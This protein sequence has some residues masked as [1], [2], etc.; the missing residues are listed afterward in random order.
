[1]FDYP[2]LKKGVMMYSE[3]K[4]SFL[5]INPYH[6]SPQKI[7]RL[8]NNESFILKMI[9]GN[10][11]IKEISRSLKFTVKDVLRTIN[12]FSSPEWNAI[13]LL[14][15]PLVRLKTKQIGGD[16]YRSIAKL[17]HC[18]FFIAKNFKEN[19]ETIKKYHRERISDAM[20]Q[21]NAVEVTVSHVYREPHVLLNRKNYGAAFADTLINNGALRNGINILEIGGGTGIFGR[22][23]LDEVKAAAPEIYKT[24]QY[25]F[26][27]LSPVLLK[28]QQ[29]ISRGH[30][31]ITRFIEGDIESYNFRNAKL[32]LII[33]NEMIADLNVVK[34]SKADFEDT[35]ALKGDRKRAADII[36]KY[37]ISISNAPKEF[38]FNLKA[39]EFLILIKKIL[40][41]GGKAY[42]VEYGSRF[43]YS[44]PKVLKGHVEYSIH[45]GHLKRVA[46]KLHMLPK[47]SCLTDF[48]GFD[49]NIKVVDKVSWSAINDYLLPF[50]KHKSLTRKVYTEEMIKEAIGSIFNRLS[51]VSFSCV[52]KGDTLLDPGKFLVLELKG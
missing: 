1:M 34:L 17:L 45:F 22:S 28:S 33:S 16:K 48:L 18:E 38:I 25:T 10:N 49:K 39:A 27:D 46:Q 52:G 31:K 44:A 47:I 9:T 32:D 21:F 2:H 4:G 40:K 36:S 19:N 11:K 14:A 23:F 42:V 3:G 30:H 8:D 24:I 51:F 5:L 6:A 37:G 35:V 13:E 43:K 29:R 26:F 20:E 15:G 50:L 7:S 12:K 41:P